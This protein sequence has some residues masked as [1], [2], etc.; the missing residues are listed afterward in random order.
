MRYFTA[1]L[2]ILGALLGLS[3]W[4]STAAAGD[5][6]QD[7]GPGVS[8]ESNT[9]KPN[10]LARLKA[11]NVDAKA[12]LLWRVTPN[13]GVSKAT[14]ARGALEFVAPPGAYDVELLVITGK[15]DGS[16]A[17]DEY[18]S[19]VEFTGP[20]GVDPPPATPPAPKG[21]GT[22]SPAKALA[23][24]S[25]PPYGCTATIVGPRRPDGKW[26][27]LSAAHC[28]SH[29]RVGTKGSIK[30][31]DGRTFTITVGVIDATSDVSWMTLDDASVSDMPYA[32]V[33]AENP[34]VGTAIWHAGY[35]VDVP[36]NREE[37]SIT[38]AENTDGQLNMSLSVSS[39]DSGGGIFRSDTNEIVSVVCC[40]TSKGR[41]ASVWGCSANKARAARPK[42][43]QMF[44]W[45]PMAIPMIEVLHQ[46]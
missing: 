12:G 6:T 36:G 38:G 46:R 30:L 23:K 2:A 9:V 45:E 41:R 44:E 5:R 17:V 11:V 24:M 33:A 40:T 1:R 39:G 20:P 34:R 21:S 15:P 37:G 10:T 26:D 19:R 22:L 43:A 25:F 7:T 31:L 27:V 13:A 42:T 4:I 29:V 32:N 14:T 16:F 18:H 8:A 28:V 35:G 3:L